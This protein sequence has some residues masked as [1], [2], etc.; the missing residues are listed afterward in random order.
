MYSWGDGMDDWARPDAYRFAE[1]RKEAR[2]AYARAA[3]S[4]GGR[5]YQSKR[6]PGPLADATKRIRSHSPN[7][8]IVAIDVTGSMAGWPF[9]LFDRL[10]L[11]YQTLSQYRPD[12]EVAY[13][14]IGDAACDRFPLQVTDFAK[15]YDLE[16]R[17]AA[18]YGEGGGGDAPEDYQLFAHYVS[19]RVDI[20][21]VADDRDER[22]FLLV[23]GDAGF[24]ARVL[25]DQVRR[26]IG[27]ELDQALDGVSVWREVAARWDTWF[28]RRPTGGPGDEVHRQWAEA[29]GEQKIVYVDDEL[30]GMDYAMGIVA[31]AWGH[32]G[33]FEANI[34]ARQDEGK[35]AAVVNS[36]LALDATGASADAG[37]DG[38]GRPRRGK[39]RKRGKSPRAIPPTRRSS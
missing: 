18:L 1:A 33:D 29:I 4:R 38:H 28:L 36:V 27:A 32:F 39:K 5:T 23:F 22:P 6:A 11:F 21:E 15:G 3:D 7:P 12:V 34:R 25:P 26:V 10:P 9:E 19:S 31:R 16:E 8:V 30:R 37:A 17:V 20:P 2:A 14:A 13:A 24:H 35:V